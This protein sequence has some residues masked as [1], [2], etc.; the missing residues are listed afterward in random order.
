MAKF[1]VTLEIIAE[2]D[3]RSEVETAMHKMLKTTKAG[4]TVSDY[5]L[6]VDYLD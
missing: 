3:Y 4:I 6:D 1:I 2:A 5:G